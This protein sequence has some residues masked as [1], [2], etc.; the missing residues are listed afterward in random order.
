MAILF[1]SIV[2]LA[3]C[4]LN[5]ET[6]KTERDQ[7]EQQGKLM[8]EAQKQCGM[9]TLVNFQERKMMKKVSGYRNKLSPRFRL[10]GFKTLRL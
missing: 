10:W 3:S 5:G 9:P 8:S 2:L 4:N 6:A 1:A 7:T